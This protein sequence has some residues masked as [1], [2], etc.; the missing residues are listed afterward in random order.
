[1]KI[2][3]C[4]LIYKKLS[5]HKA[6]VNFFKNVNK[7]RYEIYCHAKYFKKS[8]NQKLLQGKHIP[9]KIK[10]EWAKVSLVEA[11]LELFRNAHEDGCDYVFLLSGECVPI[12][13]F[14]FIAN[15][16]QDKKSV[17][18]FNLTSS[19]SGAQSG[20]FDSNEN[21]R[22]YKESNSIKKYVDKNN[23]IKADQWVGLNKK[24]VITLTKDKS[25]IENFNDV[26]AADEHY[27]PTVL[28]KN[29]QLLDAKQQA[30]TFT[31]WS[32]NKEWRHP[33]LFRNITPKELEKAKNS[34]AF[35]LRKVPAIS[36]FN[37][38]NR[39]YGNCTFRLPKGKKYIAFIHIPK[40]GGCSVKKYL[41]N[42]G[43][44]LKF[45]HES[46]RE[47]KQ[48]IS[49][50]L[51]EET[52]T[53]TT[54]RNPWS[55]ILSAFNF[56]KAGGLPQFNDEEKAKELR[57]YKDTSFVDWVKENESHF[58]NAR[59]PFEGTAGWMHFKRQTSYINEP[60]DKIF[61]IENIN[62]KQGL[63]G[64]GFMQ[65]IP[66]D[67]CSGKKQNYRSS[68]NNETIKIIRSAY[69]EDI[70]LFKYSF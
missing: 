64:R 38:V 42:D 35:F 19:L 10:T 14:N 17:I 11:S 43:R 28:N 24:D 16:I 13:S 12:H 54:V 45:H 7:E 29:R 15:Q 36:T 39:F 30:V 67:N 65:T 53:F 47:I 3:F 4:F 20:Y 70:K 40:N 1:M 26:F 37:I 21:E 25:L 50:E 6:W 18:N 5:Q 62:N 57:I 44:F 32:S 23:F 66:T 61:K 41:K 69:E 59:E 60:L 48:N 31:D 8:E 9:E 52:Y 27:V 22:R 63:I 33:K 2:G 49:K 34:G 56:L 51:W 46:A 55:R 58:K 68:Y